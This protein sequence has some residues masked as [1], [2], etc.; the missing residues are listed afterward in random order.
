[1]VFLWLAL[2]MVTVFT[3]TWFDAGAGSGP[4]TRLAAAI[5]LAFAEWY[6]ANSQWPAA[7]SL[8]HPAL[9]SFLEIVGIVLG[10]LLT[11]GLSAPGS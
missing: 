2:A 3:L 5:G 10:S 8:R 7:G 6:Y 4:S 9:C 11:A 1:M